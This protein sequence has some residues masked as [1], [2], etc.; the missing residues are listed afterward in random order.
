M[1][2]EIIYEDEHYIA[3]NKPSGL[4]VH[5]TKL[6]KKDIA[7]FALQLLRDQIQQ[8]VYPLHRIDRPTSGILLF[9][10][11]SEAAAL[12]SPQ[13]QSEEM[14]KIYLTVVRGYPEPTYGWIEKPLKKQLD[15]EDQEAKTEYWVINQIEIPFASTPKYP[16]SRYSLVKVKIHTGRMHQIRRHFAHKRNYII[17]DTSHGEN[18]QNKFF[19]S[20]FE[21][22]N[23]MLHSWKLSF[24]HPYT[25]QMVYLNA[26]IPLHFEKIL[27]AFNWKLEI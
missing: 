7:L 14:E 12:L 23:L 4:L 16:T 3:I 18:K 17:G 9:S 13:F 10:K 21:V 15:G 19:R 5:K 8:R 26:N 22:H 11:S 6:A 2:L 27:N 24:K 20:Q 25:H 1:E